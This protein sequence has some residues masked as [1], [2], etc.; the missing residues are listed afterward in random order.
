MKIS[1][2]TFLRLAATGVPALAGV[3]DFTC[4]A[5]LAQLGRVAAKSVEIRKEPDPESPILETLSKDTLIR[6]RRRVEA[7]NPC[8]NPFW[9]QVEDGYIHSGDVQP[10]SF[11]PQIPAASID[12]TTPAEVSVP[13]TQSYRTLTP[14]PEPLYRL[15]YKSIHWV[16]A[17][18][19]GEDETVWYVMRD[20]RLGLDYYAAGEDLRLISSDAF[21]PLNTDVEPWKKRMEI[22]LAD[23]SLTAYEEKEIVFET[24]VSAGIPGVKETA[25]PQGTF[26]IQIK[27]ASTHMGN[28]R[29][30]ADPLAYELPGV[31]WVSYF[32]IERGVAL[33]GAYW[34]NDFGRA[35]SHGC[36]NLRPEDALWLYRWTNPAAEKAEIKGTGGYGT[37]VIIR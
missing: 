7:E 5:A 35:R 31:P 20:T 22:R 33:H 3:P 15:Y 1:R 24:N 16:K 12:Q 26:H 30:T 37:R 21:A 18:Q 27:V 4:R 9:L 29:I 17:V 32:E 34:H 11:H 36:V 14:E 23:Q 13:V 19:V 28:G 10:V 8:G 2:R 25:T 6:I